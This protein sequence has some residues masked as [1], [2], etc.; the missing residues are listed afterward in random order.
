MVKRRTGG[1]TL[2]EVLV[3]MSIFMVVLLIMFTLTREMRNYDK[4]MPVNMMRHPQTNAV[5][6]RLRKDV[7]C[8]LSSTPFK[9]SFQEYSSDDVLI[10]ETLN[11]S[12]YVRTIVWDFR[13][14]GQAIRREYNVGELSSEWIARGVPRIVANVDLE[15]NPQSVRVQ[16]KDDSGK[17]A[18]DQTYTPRTHK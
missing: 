11:D 4:K 15:E 5:L 7:L 8:G 9:D 6:S 14:A 17:L 10:V 18:I 1:F 2:A 3:S 13:V 16:A 12:A